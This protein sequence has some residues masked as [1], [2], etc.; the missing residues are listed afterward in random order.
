MT[1]T[2][3]HANFCEQQITVRKVLVLSDTL[4]I[5]HHAACIYLFIIIII[6]CMYSN[7]Y[8][9]RMLS[10]LGER[11][12]RLLSESHVL[13]CTVNDVLSHLY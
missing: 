10:I 1:Y 13:R 8:T 4:D 7:T 5:R 3:V 6:T 11:E 2:E 12:L 9:R